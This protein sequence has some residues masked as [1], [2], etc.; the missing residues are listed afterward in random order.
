MKATAKNHR[1]VRSKYDIQ[2]DIDKIREAFVDATFDVK[3]RANEIA[4]QAIANARERSVAAKDGA[5]NFIQERPF[6]TIG[7]AMLTGIV[8][9][10]FIHKVAD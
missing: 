1:K 5:E 7:V 8:I 10:Y 4:K 9:G 3:G 6:K 2:S